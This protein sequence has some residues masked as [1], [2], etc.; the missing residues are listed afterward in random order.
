MALTP[1]EYAENEWLSNTG[2][3]VSTLTSFIGTLTEYQK[4]N[5]T[6][7]IN[8]GTGILKRQFNNQ[9][10]VFQLAQSEIRSIFYNGTTV[11]RRVYAL[12]GSSTTAT[13]VTVTAWSATYPKVN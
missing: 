11:Y 7:N 2:T 6:I 5:L 8:N 3:T 13:E 10:G 4:D 9:W 1:M 12:G